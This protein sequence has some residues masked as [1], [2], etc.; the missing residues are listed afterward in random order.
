MEKIDYQILKI[1]LKELD[2]QLKNRV[3]IVAFGG[4]SLTFLG[5][6][7][8]SEDI[9]LIIDADKATRAE[10]KKFLHEKLGVRIDVSP[11]GRISPFYKLP[12][13]YK[14]RST[15]IEKLNVGL[16][17]IKLYALDPLDVLVSKIGRFDSDDAKDIQHIISEKNYS[18]LDIQNR[19]GLFL[20][21]YQKDK[22]YLMGKF[23][24]FERI[25][26]DEFGGKY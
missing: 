21:G 16:K 15:E 5:L 7:T 3:D 24:D 8:T 19:F 20:R 6:K 25:Y 1:N 23:R 10:I 12:S 2:K 18:F 9:D 22:G 11:K 17:H 13:D 14:Q 4:T 26:E